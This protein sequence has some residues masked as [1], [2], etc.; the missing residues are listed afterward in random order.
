LF[1]QVAL[2]RQWGRIGRAGHWREEWFDDVEDAR[3][4]LAQQQTK[5]AKRGYR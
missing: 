2:V 4:A 5:K 3:V 1:G